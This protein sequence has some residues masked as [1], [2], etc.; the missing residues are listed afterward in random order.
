M[1]GRQ[2]LT[3]ACEEE[4]SASGPSSKRRGVR[5]KTAENWIAE[6]DKA[7]NTSVWL[8]FEV[9]DRDHVSLLKCAVCSQ[10]QHKLESIRNFRPA[11]I[12]GTSNVRTSTFKEHAATEMHARAMVFIYK[13]Q[14]AGDVHEYA[15]IA[16][17][18]SQ[19][20]MDAT[21]RERTKR[22]FDITYAIVKENLAFTKMKPLCEL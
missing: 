19:V 7:L 15:P 8:K 2:K 22:K 4:G 18:L 10:F 6:N 5:I 14:G 13:K 9:S 17:A 11:F 1:S 12:Q 20:S 3:H 16:R 21:T